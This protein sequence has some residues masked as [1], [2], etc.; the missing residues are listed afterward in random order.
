LGNDDF[1]ATVRVEVMQLLRRT[2]SR[3]CIALWCGNSEIEQQTAMLGLPSERWS[4][5]FF[6]QTLPA[7]CQD[8]RPDVPYWPSSPSGGTLPFH[9]DAGDAHYFGYGPYLRDFDDVRTS[10]VR[11]ASETLAF[12]HVPDLA[13]IDLVPGGA[14]GA[15]HHPGWKAAVPRDNGSG[16]DFEDVRDFYVEKF[17]H[18]QPAQLRYFDTDRYLSL[19]RAASSEAITR[20]VAEWRR[21]GSSCHGALLWFYRDLKPGAGWGIID[22][23]GRPK[24]AYYAMRR[25]SLPIAVFIADQGLNGLS[26]TLVNDTAANVPA[27]LS[28]ALYRDSE[29]LLATAKRDVTLAPHSSEAMHADSL[30]DGFRDLSYA[31]RFGPP[32]HDL[33]VATL[34]DHSSNTPIN[35][36]FFFPVGLPTARQTD[37]GLT[38]EAVSADNG[39]YHLM[40]QS[41]RFAQSVAIDVDHFRPDDN[42]F[43]LAPETTRTVVL[44]PVPGSYQVPGMSS[45]CHR[46]E[47]LATHRPSGTATPLNATAATRILVR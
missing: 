36:A 46:G 34:T 25:A 4:S 22:A 3:A 35:D 29:F 40:L 12:A 7:W 28:V 20:A 27:R 9:V 39:V 13:T 30:F 1:A 45:T 24:A 38:A 44:R 47:N 15:G 43:H 2:E 37:L 16:W 5:A 11:F 10:H 31:Y 26:L 19:G 23:T 41:Q 17:F 6:Q 32:N 18:V 21:P 8:V 14:S 42:Y 33:V